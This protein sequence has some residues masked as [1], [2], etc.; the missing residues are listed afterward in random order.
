MLA[1]FVSL[2]AFFILNQEL[3]LYPLTFGLIDLESGGESLSLHTVMVFIFCVSI[4]TLAL[5]ATFGF[6]AWYNSRANRR[7]LGP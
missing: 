3:D 1:A 4:F 5:S 7:L 6:V 2:P